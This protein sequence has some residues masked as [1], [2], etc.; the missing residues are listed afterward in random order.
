MVETK[1][2]HKYGK[3]LLYNIYDDSAIQSI[4]PDQIEFWRNAHKQHVKESRSKG[5]QKA[6]E[7]REIRR[8]KRDD[9]YTEVGEKFKLLSD[10]NEMLG[11]TYLLAFWTLWASR[12]AKEYQ[13][14]RAVSKTPH[15]QTDKTAYWYSL[16]KEA[17]GLLVTS[18]VGKL[19]FYEPP[20]PKVRASL[21]EFHREEWRDSSLSLGFGEFV[22]QQFEQLVR[23]NECEIDQMYFAL[24]FLEIKS[25][26]ADGWTFSFHTPYSVGSQFLPDPA[27]LPRVFHTREQEGMFR[28]GRTLQDVEK[29]IYSERDVKRNL[30]GAMSNY[31]SV[32]NSQELSN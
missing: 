22:E 24:Y 30:Q 10:I 12:W 11:A 17:I 18:P 25:P 19:S 3:T 2:F 27:V 15:L 6:S 23:C 8:Q 28:F 31:L 26:L 16:K 9:V 13:V 29:I 21:C 5:A 20:K 7:T 32:A 1:E 14:K 4:S